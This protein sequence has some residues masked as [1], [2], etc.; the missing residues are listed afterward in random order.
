MNWIGIQSVTELEVSRN[1]KCHWTG[2]NLIWIFQNCLFNFF[3]FS[4]TSTSVT[5]CLPIQFIDTSSN[6]NKLIMI[7]LA[8]RR[9]HERPEG[10]APPNQ[11]LSILL[12]LTHWIGFSKVQ[13]FCNNTTSNVQCPMSMSN[14]QCLK[15]Y[16]SL[17]Y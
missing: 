6:T 16:Q 5:L 15:T 2:W 13:V 12:S 1:W 17:Q 8:K 9:V 4:D 3:Q 14:V 11:I 7:I 10:L